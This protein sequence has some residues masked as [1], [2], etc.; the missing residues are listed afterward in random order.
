MV[1]FSPARATMSPAAIAM[2][3]AGTC[4]A[5]P[6]PIVSF[7]KTDTVLPKSQPLMNIPMAMP[8]MMFTPVMISAAMAS[9]RTNLLAPSIAP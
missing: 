6:S 2:M 5:R 9:P 1:C 4:E 3:K 8:P 7:V